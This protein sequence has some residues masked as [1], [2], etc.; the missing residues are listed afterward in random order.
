MR[1]F[2]P[3][4]FVVVGILLSRPPPARADFGLGL[5]LG[6][7]TGID[8]KIGMG[9]RSG[10]DLLFGFNTFR[11]GRGGYGHVTYL[12]TPLVGQGGSVLV[13]LR[14]GV[15]AALYG[16][17]DDLD[18]AIRAPL[19][20]GIRLRSSPLEFYGEIALAFTLFD[21]GADALQIDVQGGVGFRLYF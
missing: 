5:F 1:T 11:E 3:A 12:V 2:L 15:G 19:E 18:F 17:S 7:P 6:E 21:A 20:V 14:L 4:S 16:T 8:L 9:H 13:P 10:L